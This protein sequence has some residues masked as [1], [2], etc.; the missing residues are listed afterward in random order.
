[1]GKYAQRGIPDFYGQLPAPAAPTSALPG[2]PEK[3]GVL[4][5]RAELRQSLWHPKDATLD[6]PKVR[7]AQW[8]A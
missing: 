3:V 1:L 7:R 4:V 6:L 2:T 8:P 5:K